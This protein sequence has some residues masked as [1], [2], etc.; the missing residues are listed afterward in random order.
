[1]EPKNHLVKWGILSVEEKVKKG[2]PRADTEPV[3][4]RLPREI[5][6]RLDDYRRQLD[7]LPNRPEAI[8]RIISQFLAQQDNLSDDS[9]KN[10]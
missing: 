3:N 1:M 8:R 5:I 10:E 9:S 4:L 7:D 2:R 6:N